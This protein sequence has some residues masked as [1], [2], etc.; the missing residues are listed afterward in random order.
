MI[1]KFRKYLICFIILI[2]VAFVGSALPAESVIPKQTFDALITEVNQ[3]PQ[4][5][6]FELRHD[7]GYLFSSTQFYVICVYAGV[8]GHFI[9]ISQIKDKPVIV[10]LIQGPGPENTSALTGADAIEYL[11]RLGIDTSALDSL[12]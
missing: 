7:N 3:N 12:I 5:K 1:T 11:E 2:A 4:P 6:P 8:D 10:E 9:V